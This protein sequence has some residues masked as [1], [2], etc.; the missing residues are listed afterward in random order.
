MDEAP[1]SQNSSSGAACMLHDPLTR[2]QPRCGIPVA[3]PP[4]GAS[5]EGVDICSSEQRTAFWKR[6][7]ISLE[8]V[9]GGDEEYFISLERIGDVAC[10]SMI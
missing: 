8:S 6:R 1:A 5:A 10:P 3:A 4:A 7:S 2:V 9:F